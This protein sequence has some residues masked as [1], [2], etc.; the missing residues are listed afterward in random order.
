MSDSSESVAETGFCSD[1]VF[2]W[3]Y[4]TLDELL[5]IQQTSDEDLPSDIFDYHDTLSAPGYLEQAY[6]QE[7][8]FVSLHE[9]ES[10]FEDKM[11]SPLLDHSDNLILDKKI[12]LGIQE[13]STLTRSESV[14]EARKCPETQ[15]AVL[16]ENTD[17]SLNV[18]FIVD[19]A[20][21]NKLT[22]SEEQCNTEPGLGL[23]FQQSQPDQLSIRDDGKRES[24]R[25]FDKR[26]E[27][28]TK[29]LRYL[30]GRTIPQIV[31]ASRLLH[32]GFRRQTCDPFSR[33]SG[34]NE[35]RHRNGHQTSSK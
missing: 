1:A 33:L 23:K 9:Y 31:G 20:G 8:D 24:G 19:S 28:N 3:S 27:W 22:L 11:S 6:P 10:F 26:E 30:R 2:S 15:S 29:S 4:P 13:I 18:I 16:H 34:T 32:L 21:I 14:A 17:Q 5:G 12:E 7:L 25:L 35:S